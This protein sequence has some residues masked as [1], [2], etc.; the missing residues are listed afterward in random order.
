[1]I[2]NV[3]TLLKIFSQSLHYVQVYAMKD[4]ID[5]FQLSKTAPSPGRLIYDI[6]PTMSDYQKL[7][8]NFAILVAHILVKHVPYFTQDFSGL[9]VNH[10]PHKYSLE[11][12]KNLK[13]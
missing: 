12:A 6:L 11:M 8:D 4:R 2:N 3:H 1:M 10:I 9:L 5:F 13:L 7:K